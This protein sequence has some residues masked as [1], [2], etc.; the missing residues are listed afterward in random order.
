MY[1]EAGKLGIIGVHEDYIVIICGFPKIRC[2]ILGVPIIRIIVFVG[3]Y[4]GPPIYGNYHIRIIWGYIRVH[5]DAS[6]LQP[7]VD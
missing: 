1:G 6:S 7:R 3:P 5:R 2:T 4:W